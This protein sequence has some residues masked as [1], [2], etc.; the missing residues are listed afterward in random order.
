MTHITQVMK[1]K[2]HIRYS[3]LMMLFIVTSLNYGD[4]AVLAIAGAP[5]SDELGITTISMGFIFSAFS[6]AYTV[7]Q[8]PGGW[9]LDKYGA[10]RVYFLSIFLWSLFTF[11]QG[12]VYLFEGIQLWGWVSLSVV[13]LFL[14]RFIVGLSECPAF[15]G[16]SKIVS[17]WF[18]KQERGTASA[19]FNSG[20]Y[21]AT[22]FF[23][24]LMGWLVQRIGWHSAFFF[25][26]IV[27]II[28]SFVWLKVIYSPLEHPRISKSELDFMRD[29]GALIE[30]DG[31]NGH[32]ATTAQAADEEKTS[33]KQLLSNRLL[34]GVYIGQYCISTLTWFFISWFPIYLVKERGMTILNAGFAASL[35]AICGFVGGILGGIFSDFLLRRGYSLSAARKTPIILGMLCSMSMVFCNYTSSI[36][37]VIFLMSFSFFGKGFGALGWA[38]VADTSPKNAI[39]LSGGVFNTIGNISGIV[40]PIVIGF[41]VA[42]S[43]SFSGAL[44]YVS[45][46]AALAIFCYLFLVG[47]IKRVEFTRPASGAQKSSLS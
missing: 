32:A 33:I 8:I 45:V 5:M 2:T 18:P 6:W 16:N 47:D 31:K 40:T 29:G 21:F 22:A 3:I 38:V 20:Q 1:S 37:L 44:I 4:R 10:K 43:G 42:K 27:G 34:L 46:F 24:P 30:M 39:G 28:I 13:T 36:G 11:L 7:G 17:A 15:P 12:F 9:L 19:I 25:M 41:I 23:V 35:P 26:G 14:L